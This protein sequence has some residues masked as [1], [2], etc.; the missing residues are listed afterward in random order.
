MSPQDD[1]AEKEAQLAGRL[2]ALGAREADIE[3]TFVRSGGRGGQNV[4]KTAT[5]VML[6]HRP[7]GIQVKCQSTRQQGQNRILARQILVA[8]LEERR[9]REIADERSRM[10][11]AQRQKRKR[12][13]SAKERMLADKGRQAAKKAWR[14]PVDLD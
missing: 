8:K 11:K 7:T 4:N 13:R 6:V 9:H 1:R 5:C 12:S 2:A 3:E 14:R 10:A